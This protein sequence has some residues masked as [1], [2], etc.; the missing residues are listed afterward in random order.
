MHEYILWIKLC[1][2]VPLAVIL[3]IVILALLAVT[4]SKTKKLISSQ[5]TH[6]SEGVGTSGGGGTGRREP[7]CSC[8]T[9]HALGSSITGPWQVVISVG[10]LIDEKVSQHALHLIQSFEH[11]DM[12]A[13][14][15]AYK[16][17]RVNLS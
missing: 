14:A 6:W 8:P 4:A 16:P 3:I 13:L 7:A 12:E 5:S 1:I 9:V 10:K 17:C 2:V 11:T 15:C